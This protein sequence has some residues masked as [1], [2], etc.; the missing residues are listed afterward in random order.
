LALG[1]HCVGSPALV[2]QMAAAPRVRCRALR[3]RH[4]ALKAKA[5]AFLMRPWGRRFPQK[6]IA[7]DDRKLLNYYSMQSMVALCSSDINHLQQQRQCG[8]MIGSTDL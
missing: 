2:A 6:D 4:S 5:N 1:S 8:M 7:N 3:S